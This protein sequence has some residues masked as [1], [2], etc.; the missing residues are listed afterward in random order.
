MQ[1]E[2]VI[3]AL[4]GCCN[5]APATKQS[6]GGSEERGKPFWHQNASGTFPFA[7]MLGCM[8]ARGRWGGGGR[9]GR[10]EGL[11]PDCNATQTLGVSNM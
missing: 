5:C 8:A 11:P 9:E 2:D 4:H 3:S 1:D 6:T 10:G 7:A